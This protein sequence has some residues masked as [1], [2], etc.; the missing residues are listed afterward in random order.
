MLECA[1]NIGVAALQWNGTVDV[2]ISVSSFSQKSRV[3]EE[4]SEVDG[5]RRV[6]VEVTSIKGDAGRMFYSQLEFLYDMTDVIYDFVL[7]MN[8]HRDPEMLERGTEALC[9]TRE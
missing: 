1:S 5:V 4:V 2:H 8:T 6:V 9:G 3:I 7:N